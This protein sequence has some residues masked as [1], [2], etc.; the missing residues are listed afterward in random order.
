M[1]VQFDPKIFE[2]TSPLQPRKASAKDFS[3]VLKEAIEEVN[4]LQFEADKAIKDLA[5]GKGDLHET[6]IAVEK[7]EISF[8]L[9]MQIRNKLIKAYEEVMRMQL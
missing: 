9:M 1:K 3:E 5:L 4:R 2:P 8:R 7:A 6:I